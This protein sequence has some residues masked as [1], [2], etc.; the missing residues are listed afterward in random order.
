MPMTKLDVT[1]GGFFPRY[2]TRLILGNPQWHIKYI[3]LEQIE[4]SMN[5]RIQ[6]RK[7]QRILAGRWG[8]QYELSGVKSKMRRLPI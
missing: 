1:D 2:V 5:Q 4:D 3:I 8:L 6:T 7:F